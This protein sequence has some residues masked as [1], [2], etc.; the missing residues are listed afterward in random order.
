MVQSLPSRL[1]DIPDMVIWDESHHRG[2]RTYES[3][4]DHC[5][6]S[7]HLGLTATPARGD[8]K[9]LGAYFTSMVLGPSVAWLISEGYLS[10]YRYFAP[11]VPS[12]A[13]VPVTAGEYNTKA[14]EDIMGGKA[15][16]GNMVRQ[17]QQN[18]AGLVTLG[19]APSVKLSKAYSAA[20]SEAG[21]ASGHLDGTSPIDERTRLM[22]AWARRELS[23]LWNVDLFGEGSDLAAQT[24][25]DITIESVILGAPTRSLPRNRQRLGRGLRAKPI[26]AIFLDHCGDLSRHP[27]PDAE[28]QWSLDAP[29]KVVRPQGRITPMTRCMDCFAVFN[30]AP[31]CP[32]C[33]VQ[34]EIKER[35][36]I[37][38]EGDLKEI[39][40][41]EVAAK[42]EDDE[43][44]RRDARRE[45]G[46][47]RSLE[48][49]MH[50][51]AARGYHRKWAYHKAKAR[52]YI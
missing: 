16:V 52:G 20:F 33:G 37:Y 23:V 49:F 51:A 34:R 19:F 40:A 25:H 28:I 12:M 42:K 29:A 50:I 18:A 39:K 35:Q 2:S 13:G 45:E 26:P 38:L 8:G 5:P 32:V 14:V 17:W 44:A 7:Y 6:D 3:I 31:S 30:P 47:A 1:P 43:R 10:R 41:Q 9:P 4:A 46:M 48:D 11:D 15:I 22:E 24:G 36:V 27:L 21:I